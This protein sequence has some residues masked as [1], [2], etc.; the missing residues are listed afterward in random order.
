MWELCIHFAPSLETVRLFK[1]QIVCST[2][3][4]HSV[5]K[6]MASSR[7]SRHHSPRLNPL[8]STVSR[9]I[10]HK[11]TVS[12]RLPDCLGFHLDESQDGWLWCFTETRLGSS[13]PD[14]LCCWWQPLICQPQEP[15]CWG[16]SLLTTDVDRTVRPCAEVLAFLALVPENI[17]LP[18][19][20][21]QVKWTILSVLTLSALSK[22]Q[23]ACCVTSA[24]VSGFSMTDLGLQVNGQIYSCLSSSVKIGKGGGGDQQKSSWSHQ[25][26][27]WTKSKPMSTA[28]WLIFNLLDKST[29]FQTV[30][31]LGCGHPG[32]GCLWRCRS[33]AWKDKWTFKIHGEHHWRCDTMQ[34]EKAAGEP[35]SLEVPV[36]QEFLGNGRIP[37]NSQQRP[38]WCQLSSIS[39]Q[40]FSNQY[41][42]TNWMGNFCWSE[43]RNDQ[44]LCEMLFALSFNFLTT[45][46]SF[47]FLFF[48]YFLLEYNCFTMLC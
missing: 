16:S 41:E 39:Q 15:E 35:S 9:P 13:G 36:S 6:S 24:S 40:L 31:P 17:C 12:H 26:V 18:R 33:W 22:Q 7:R 45:R 1:A 37:K 3:K 47:F 42:F 10:S 21:W 34:E 44:A 14:A 46:P 27:E 43:W 32:S 28:V 30:G 2:E 23:T 29:W 25:S 4:R 11:D 8:G 48:F 5:R 19:G 38:A 20:H